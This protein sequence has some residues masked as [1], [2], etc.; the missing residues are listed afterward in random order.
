M[1][2]VVGITIGDII[3]PN[4]APNLIHPLFK[5]VNIL[6]LSKPSVKNINEIEIKKNLYFHY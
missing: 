3:I 5:G 6:E 1:S 2:K 4:T